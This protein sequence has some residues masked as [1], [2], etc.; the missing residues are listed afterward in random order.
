MGNDRNVYS[1]PTSVPHIKA[2][3]IEFE[4]IKQE[5]VS[6]MRRDK[7]DLFYK[8]EN[9]L[10]STSYR[11]GEEMA[12]FTVPAFKKKVNWIVPW[13]QGYEIPP[14]RDEKESQF[15]KKCFETVR[16]NVEAPVPANGILNLENTM[17]KEFSGDFIFCL[18]HTGLDRVIDMPLFVCLVEKDDWIPS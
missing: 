5:A 2:V 11:S 13:I 1:I 6:D 14:Q 9:L 7:T 8:V 17:G 4:G 3:F 12:S 15:I 10:K 16:I 18:T